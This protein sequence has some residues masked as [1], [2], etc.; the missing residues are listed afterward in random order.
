M[1]TFHLVPSQGKLKDESRNIYKVQT[2]QRISEA[3]VSDKLKNLTPH[4]RIVSKEAAIV[5]GYRASSELKVIQ[6]GAQ[7]TWW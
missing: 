1:S 3:K 4:E 6:R 5:R 7:V 2:P